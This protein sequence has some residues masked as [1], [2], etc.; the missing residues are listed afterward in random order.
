MYLFISLPKKTVETECL[1]FSLGQAAFKCKLKGNLG[2][3]K[4]IYV[5]GITFNASIYNMLKHVLDSNLTTLLKRTSI[6]S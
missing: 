5:L 2:Y 6:S 4:H 3:R 1:Y